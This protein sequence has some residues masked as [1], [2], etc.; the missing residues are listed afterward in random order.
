[1]SK[2]TK[3]SPNVPQTP[4]TQPD[5]AT[6]APADAQQSAQTPTVSDDIG[7]IPGAPQHEVDQPTE[8]SVSRLESLIKNMRSE[9]PAASAAPG[10]TD[11]PIDGSATFNSDSLLDTLLNSGQL[12]GQDPA[13]VGATLKALG[14]SLS[15]SQRASYGET[16]QQGTYGPNTIL[17]QNFTWG[18]NITGQGSNM[19]L[20]SS[21]Q[22]ALEK[23]GAE[24]LPTD[25]MA[26]VQFVLRESYLGTTETLY[27]F[28]NKV[29]Y[30]NEAKRQMR[31]YISDLRDFS[32][33]LTTFLQEKGLPQD[34]PKSSD[35]NFTEINTE[36]QAAIHE[37]FSTRGFTRS[38][39]IT[40]EKAGK[41]HE[42]MV[43]LQ[44]V[45]AD[46]A[47]T[48]S[49]DAMMERANQRCNDKFGCDIPPEIYASVKA[50]LTEAI[51]NDDRALL[52]QAMT[53]VAAFYSYAADAGTKNGKFGE[54]GNDD[55]THYNDA[56]GPT[57]EDFLY[58][59][60]SDAD[61]YIGDWSSFGDKADDFKAIAQDGGTKNADARSNLATGD[62]DLIKAAFGFD[63]SIAVTGSSSLAEVVNNAMSPLG[64][65]WKNQILHDQEVSTAD[66]LKN[67]QTQGMSSQYVT[68]LIGKE[69][70]GDILR[71]LPP[72]SGDSMSAQ[73]MR[74]FGIPTEIPPPGMPWTKEGLQNEIE[75]YESQLNQV[76]DDAQ[77]ANV[78]LQNWLQKQQQ[79]MQMMSNISKLLHDTAMAIIRKIG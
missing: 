65:K 37:Y 72:D 74:D 79:T 18:D 70:A 50:Q 33:G 26:F 39:A 66:M 16:F 41:A 77:L 28:A 58:Y 73:V 17:A 47:L 60:G 9:T 63:A 7:D 53:T 38:H 76:G 19:A 69:A 40:A 57:T 55:L 61:K 49:A 46:K 43:Y 15:Q 71:M 30:F 51:K 22:Q 20:N 54:G 13:V 56:K 5:T 8:Q 1:M 68:D 64:D 52:D 14:N 62:I 11:I 27:D 42:A 67:I 35:A 48:G 32:T 12:I 25:P 31:E 23:L 21:T 6:Q 36:Y 4:Q 44:D 24:G 59:I 78:D 29:K 3:N 34:P 2:I 75:D 45:I 10:D